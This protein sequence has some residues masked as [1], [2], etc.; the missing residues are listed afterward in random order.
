MDRRLY[1]S[2]F[3]N[4]A[5]RL[6]AIGEGELARGG[7]AMDTPALLRCFHTLKGMSAT[8][9]LGAIALLA[10]ALEDVCD[11]LT[12]ARLALDDTTTALLGEA[13]REIGRQVREVEAGR[14]PTP[15]PALEARV[16]AHLQANTATGFQ[17]LA[18]EPEAPAPEPVAD[19]SGTEDAVASLAE[20]LA[21]CRSLR[22]LADADPAAS[23]QLRRIEDAARRVYVRL[24]ELRQ[25]PFGTIVPPLRRRLRAVCAQLGKDAHL[26]VHGEEVR[27][28]PEVL[29]PLQGALVQLLHNAV[30][31]GIEAPAA[32][33]TKGPVGRI[34]LSAERVGR[35]LRLD[36]ADDGRGLDGPGLRG[37]AGEPDGDPAELALRPGLTTAV[38]VG[39]VSGRGMGLP[40]AQHIV[41]RLGGRLE[42]ATLPGGGTR[43]R[44]EVPL[45][46]DLAPVLLVQAGGQTLALPGRTASA[47]APAPDAEAL[48]HLPV[49]GVDGVRT[50][51]R[52][53][54]VDR[55]LGPVDALV[56]LP[57]FPLDHLPHVIGTTVAPDGHILLV[58][59]PVSVP[60]P[61]DSS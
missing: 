8:L 21:A 39:L 5:R 45:H 58:V 46:A 50:G 51:G 6:L 60:L 28:D 17:L 54:R 42:I 41:D 12:T 35:S 1:Q 33:G 26:E 53:V 57:P 29:G 44:M 56:S 55:V 4:E 61:R 3:V 13:L 40:A 52:V 47:C 59:D 2:L 27:V 48:L 34:V 38:G 37:L 9:E 49:G 10:H 18:G 14:E 16:R 24:A 31:H 43:L 23:T 32:R 19:A 30:A 15:D 7:A 36:F 20:M 11:G 25:V 22:E